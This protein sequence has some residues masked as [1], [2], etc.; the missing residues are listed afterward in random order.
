VRMEGDRGAGDEREGPDGN[1]KV[2]AFVWWFVNPI[3]HEQ[4]HQGHVTVGVG[5]SR[6]EGVQCTRWH[7]SRSGYVSCYT[8]Q[9][10][11]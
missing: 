8:T 6:T 11:S 5:T 2:I 1:G 10:S 7:R 9:L 3:D 4:V